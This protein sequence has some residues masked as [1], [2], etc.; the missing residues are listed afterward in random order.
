MYTQGRAYCSIS[1]EGQIF[2]GTNFLRELSLTEHI[3]YSFPVFSATLRDSTG[4]M[5]NFLAIRDGTKIN[6][7]IGSSKENQ[8][9]YNFRTISYTKSSTSGETTWIINGVLDCPKYYSMSKRAAYQ[10][11][12]NDCLN[13]IAQDSGLIYVGTDATFDDNQVW[14]ATGDTNAVFAQRI[15]D[16][17]YCNDTSATMIAT[18]LEGKLLYKDLNTQIQLPAVDDFY[19]GQMVDED[20]VSN[21]TIFSSNSGF[22]NNWLGTGVLRA[23]TGISGVESTLSSIPVT[24]C[25]NF[26]S[27][28]SDVKSAVQYTKIDCS[29]FNAGNTHANYE[30]A[31]YQ[32]IRQR[33][34]FSQYVDMLF[35][36]QNM[37]L[38]KLLDCIYLHINDPQTSEI[39][40]G[41]GKYLVAG[42]TTVIHGGYLY[43]QRYT[44]MRNAVTYCGQTK[45]LS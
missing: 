18:T 24:N 17:G 45:L 38:A 16:H 9:S 13:K 41:E 31:F 34:L 23:V 35:Y 25:E 43:A 26:L 33:S 12:S 36:E 6:I 10:G 4:A 39:A 21:E 32:N 30:K 5:D 11:T 37:P 42:I 14:L 22:R 1:I 15:A 2:D 27:V 8:H 19:L 3:G 29:E 44:V 7:A 20:P 40:E 28:N